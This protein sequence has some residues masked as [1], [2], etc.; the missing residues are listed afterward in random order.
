MRSSYPA[1]AVECFRA[2][3]P[4]RGREG[5]SS[6]TLQHHRCGPFAR[7]WTRS[8]SSLCRGSSASAGNRDRFLSVA[9]PPANAVCPPNTPCRI[10]SVDGR[11]SRIPVHL[12]RLLVSSALNSGHRTQDA[13]PLNLSITPAEVLYPLPHPLARSKSSQTAASH[14][15]S[16]VLARS[17]ELHRSRP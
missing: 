12:Q 6:H 16:V 1:S 7:G 5:R 14:P 8:D 9:L 2:E 11:R 10:R 13:S 3:P 17:G 15:Q 4:T